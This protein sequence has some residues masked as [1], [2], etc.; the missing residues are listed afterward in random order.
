MISFTTKWRK[1]TRFLTCNATPSS[2][3]MSCGS[4]TTKS[5]KTV[6]FCEFTL[7]LTRA[8]LCRK[9]AFMNKWLK[10]TVRTGDVHVGASVLVEL[11][12]VTPDLPEKARPHPALVEERVHLPNGVVSRGH[13][14]I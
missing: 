6:A 10:T 2:I 8:Y 5:E 13:S 7:C 9:I 14:R 11:A 1:K 12:D 4:C 3:C